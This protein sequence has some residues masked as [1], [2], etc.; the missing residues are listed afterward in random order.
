MY[1][2]NPC[3]ISQHPHSRRLG[4][5]ALPQFRWRKRYRVIPLPPTYL[6]LL[7]SIPAPR[8]P[9]PGGPTEVIAAESTRIATVEAA[10]VEACGDNLTRHRGGR[11]GYPCCRRLCRSRW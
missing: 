4:A 11:V 9:N 2:E 1:C 5:A 10:T 3:R 7:T 8:V 6:P